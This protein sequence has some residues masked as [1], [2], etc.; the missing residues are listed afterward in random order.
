MSRDRI[1]EILDF[2]ST[3]EA[4]GEETAEWC[5]ERGERCEDE[6]VELH[7]G[8]VDGRWD[9]EGSGDWKIGDDARDMVDVSDEDR[10]RSA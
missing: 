2:E 10:I 3:F 6:D 8:D 5:N 1:T 7:G 4:G 9:V